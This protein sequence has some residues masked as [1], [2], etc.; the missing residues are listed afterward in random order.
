ML[1]EPLQENCKLPISDAQRSQARNRAA[2][3]DRI[4]FT[5]YH[6]DVDDLG[7]EV[8]V[9]GLILHDNPFDCDLTI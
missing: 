6:I 3:N 8:S 7:A 2:I 1:I 4:L 9:S 5:R